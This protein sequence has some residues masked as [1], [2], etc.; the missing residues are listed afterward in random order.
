MKKHRHESIF[1]FIEYLQIEKNCSENTI[2][3]YKRDLEHFSLFM[4]EQGLELF[5]DIQYF[6]ARLYLTHLYRGKLCKSQCSPK[7]I[8]S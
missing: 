8:M 5:T 7:N 3:T 4:V 6:D 2:T 1:S